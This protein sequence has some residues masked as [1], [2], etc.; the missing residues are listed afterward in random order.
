MTAMEDQEQPLTQPTTRRP[1]FYRH[2]RFYYYCV[3][4]NILVV[5]L[6]IAQN[7]VDGSS[8]DLSL[9]GNLSNTGVFSAVI[10]FPQ[11]IAVY[12]NGSQLGTTNLSSSYV[13]IGISAQFGNPFYGLPYQLTLWSGVNGI[14]ANPMWQNDPLFGPYIALFSQEFLNSTVPVS[15]NVG[16]TGA[17]GASGLYVGL[18]VGHIP[19]PF[20]NSDTFAVSSSGMA[21]KV[22]L[23]IVNLLNGLT[24]RN[25]TI[26]NATVPLA[27]NSS[28]SMPGI[29]GTSVPAT[30]VSATVPLPSSAPTSS[31]NQASSSSQ[32]APDTIGSSSS[33]SSTASGTSSSSSSS[34][35]PSVSSAQPTA[36]T[37]NTAVSV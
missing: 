37:N 24:A 9:D 20:P 11:D 27:S 22:G 34:V 30:S 19:I 6:V 25:G 33:S 23:N 16:P 36:G 13:S 29:S 31:S 8:M 15:L 35:T 4:I 3:H 10:D 21:F 32:S 18:N 12:W 17:T 28:V 1:R 2:R 26:I 5:I 14:P 7:T